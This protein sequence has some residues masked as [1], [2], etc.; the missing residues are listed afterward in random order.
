MNT[1]AILQ[2]LARA[3]AIIGVA[4][5]LKQ[6]KDTSKEL[7]KL[8]DSLKPLLLPITLVAAVFLVRAWKA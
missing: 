3:G 1:V 6:V 4:F 8:G 2:A 5:G 7:P